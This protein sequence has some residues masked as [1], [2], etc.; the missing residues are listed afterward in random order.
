M[1]TAR[2]PATRLD[3]EDIAANNVRP[4]AANRRDAAAAASG[5]RRLDLLRSALGGDF[6]AA[7]ERRHRGHRPGHRC[8]RSRWTGRRSSPTVRTSRSGDEHSLHADASRTP[9]SRDPA[10]WNITRKPAGAGNAGKD[11]SAVANR[12]PG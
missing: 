9:A 7:L 6:V 11:R 3:Q 2:D 8:P 12:R 5:D 1:A 10:E 4:F